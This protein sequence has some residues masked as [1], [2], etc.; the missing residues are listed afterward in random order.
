MKYYTQPCI[1]TP[2][3]ISVF[4]EGSNEATGAY[5][6]KEEGIYTASNFKAARS[7]KTDCLKTAVLFALADAKPERA[8]TPH[9]ITQLQLF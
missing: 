6:E 7:I 4:P 5:Q 3:I 9:P 1:F 8:K 2:S